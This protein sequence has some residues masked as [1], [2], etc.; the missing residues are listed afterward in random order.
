MN[1]RVQ[2]LKVALMRNF[3][4]FGEWVGLS[5]RHCVKS[6]K[7]AAKLYPTEAHYRDDSAVLE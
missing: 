4:L 1:W 5:V 2:G 3:Y 6:R 7:I